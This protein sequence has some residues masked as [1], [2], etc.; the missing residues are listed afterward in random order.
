MQHVDGPAHGDFYAQLV[1]RDGDVPWL[2]T[3]VKGKG[4]VKF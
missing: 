4:Y 2:A 1:Q 3:F